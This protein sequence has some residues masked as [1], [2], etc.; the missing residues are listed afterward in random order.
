[1]QILYFVDRSYEKC[2]FFRS[3][4]CSRVVKDSFIGFYAVL[5]LILYSFDQE[6]LKD[7]QHI[8]MNLSVMG[9]L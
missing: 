3:T 7:L 8:L 6:I 2:I 1:M 5:K 4:F 9:E